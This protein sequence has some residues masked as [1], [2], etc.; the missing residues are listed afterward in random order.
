MSRREFVGI[1]AETAMGIAPNR[2]S[3]VSFQV[4]RRCGRLVQGLLELFSQF[5]GT[6]LVL[7]PRR[8]NKAPAETREVMKNALLDANFDPSSCSLPCHKACI[9]HGKKS[10]TV[11]ASA[12]RRKEAQA[13][14]A[15]AGM[16]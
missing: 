7:E 3:R 12:L 2:N 8:E 9:F 1:R 13:G 14:L 16:A 5:L 11:I 10:Y 15:R 4:N 6:P